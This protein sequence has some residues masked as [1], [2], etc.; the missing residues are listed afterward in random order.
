LRG[1]VEAF[2]GPVEGAIFSN[3]SKK[4]PH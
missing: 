2:D 3:R 1:K 4:R